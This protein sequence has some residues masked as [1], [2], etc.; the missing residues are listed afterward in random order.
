MLSKWIKKGQHHLRDVGCIPYFSF[1]APR[2][3]LFFFSRDRH[4]G[5][6]P[7]PRRGKKYISKYLISKMVYNTAKQPGILLALLSPVLVINDS[8]ISGG[9][10]CPEMCLSC[11]ASR[12]KCKATLELGCWL[13]ETQK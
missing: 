12:S 5:V 8:K 4:A 7:R 9:G 10:K 13:T 11:A 3:I 1:T 6:Y 2:I